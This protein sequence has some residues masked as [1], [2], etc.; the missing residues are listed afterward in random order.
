VTERIWCDGNRSYIRL[1]PS[2][3]RVKP[4][5]CSLRL[6]RALSDFGFTHSFKSATGLI[7]EHYGFEFSETTL[8]NTTRAHA[9]AISQMQNER[10]NAGLLPARGSGKIIAEADGTFLRIVETSSAKDRRKTRKINFQEARLSAATEH[11]SDKTFY[12][13]T[14]EDTNDVGLQWAY[15]AKNAGWSLESKIHVVSD[16]AVW[17]S[18]Q[19][20]RIFGKQGTY[21]VDFYHLCEYLHNASE[22]CSHNPKQWL[23]HQ[24]KRLKRSAYSLVI[25]E[26]EGNLEPENLPDEQAPVRC[27]YRYMKNR[28]DSLDYKQAIDENLPIGSGLIESGHKHV[29]QSRMKIPGA[30]WAINNAENMIQSR[31][32]RANGFWEQYWQKIAA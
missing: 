23:K 13:A 8:A 29:L 9:Q 30:S 24:K 20:K 17:I 16:G 3:I 1:L 5:G 11:G 6:Q 7:K 21:I 25:K 2:A 15:A 28:S 27:A 22:S 10:T 31:A 14:F 4:R 18:S 12:E 26:L 32:F 19:A